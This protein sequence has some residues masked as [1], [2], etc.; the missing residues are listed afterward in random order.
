[1]YLLDFHMM[2]DSY[3]VAYYIITIEKCKGIYHEERKMSLLLFR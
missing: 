2:V 1:M 3:Y